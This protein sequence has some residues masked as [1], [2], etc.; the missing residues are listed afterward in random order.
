MDTPIFQMKRFRTPERYS[1]KLFQTHN[2]CFSTI[3]DT[4][5]VMT[6]ALVNFSPWLRICTW[7]ELRGKG[8]V[9]YV[10]E[11]REEQMVSYVPQ[12]REEQMVRVCLYVY[13]CVALPLIMGAWSMTV[14]LWQLYE[15]YYYYIVT[16]INMDHWGIKLYYHTNFTMSGAFVS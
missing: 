14:M 15:Y 10:A 12:V 1:Y 2:K 11:M 7:L 8:M 5:T 9:S 6:R 4:C 3:Q 13:V 16:E